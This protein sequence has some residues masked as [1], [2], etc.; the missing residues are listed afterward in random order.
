MP[1]WEGT[2]VPTVKSGNKVLVVA[3]GNSIRAIVKKL[4]NIS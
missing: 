1:F 4:S 3:H 2:I